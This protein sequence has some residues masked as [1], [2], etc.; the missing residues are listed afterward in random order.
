M[1]KGVADA[2]TANSPESTLS[3]QCVCVCAYCS[4]QCKPEF[5]PKCD[6]ILYYVDFDINRVA[7]HIWY[8]TFFSCYSGLSCLG[9]KEDTYIKCILM[10]LSFVLLSLKS[11]KFGMFPFYE[12]KV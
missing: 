1:I 6:H 10:K 9:I 3:L 11:G 2:A 12:G 4:I 5:G 7:I 8:C